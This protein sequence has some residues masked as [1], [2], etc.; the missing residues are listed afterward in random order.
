MH[1]PDTT[2]D[3]TEH[4]DFTE[5]EYGRLLDLTA[6]QYR[7]CDYDSQG[8]DRCV[9]WRH[10]IDASPHRALALARL[11]AERNIRCIYHVL[12]SSNHYNVL[13]P[14]VASIVKQIAEFGHEV[15][16]HF[17]MDVFGARA[18]VSERELN[19]RI[20]LEK[21]IV[22]MI[23]GAPV[24]SLSFHNFAMNEARLDRTERICGMTNASARRY[25]TEF[26]Y[27]SDS[28]GIWRHR[29][30]HD[31]LAG[32]PVPRLHVLTH[33]MWWVPEPMAP[34]ARLHRATNGR[35]RANADFYLDILKRD[36]RFDEIAARIGVAQSVSEPD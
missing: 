19:Q 13:E 31:V 26:E 2:P 9:I 6:A 21:D 4:A 12:P 25:Y 11:E 34:L 8:E 27:I 3:Q 10:D 24:R 32:E 17:D 29:R 33:P 7:F 36:G 14:A 18:S 30:L 23:V 20:G 5:V 28:N 22:A 16:L 1:N 35:A 15:G